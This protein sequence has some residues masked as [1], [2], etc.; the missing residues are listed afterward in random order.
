MAWLYYK[1]EFVAAEAPLL[2]VSDRS[3]RYGDGIFETVLVVNGN[4]YEFAAHLGRLRRGLAYFSINLD[5]TQLEA[6]CRALIEKNALINGYVRIIVSRGSEAAAVGYKPGDAAPY[7]VLQPVFKT[8]GDGTPIKL[9]HSSTQLFYHYPC[10]TNNALPYTLAFLEAA[11]HGCENAL[12]TDSAGHIAE[13]ATGNLFW[14]EG[15]TLYTPSSG[16]PMVPGTIREKVLKLW[17]GRAIEGVFPVS[18]LHTA[19]EVFMSNV[20][21]LITPIAALVPEGW[22]W[23]EHPRTLAL[24]G[25]LL[26]DIARVCA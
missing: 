1:N 2:G 24:R 15:E 10:K 20:G 12:M 11:Q 6:E 8:Y 9:H 18:A 21:G 19:D 7:A 5:T 22:H 17:P 3:F 13:T 14:I 16:L 23:P 4:M 26:N 25:A